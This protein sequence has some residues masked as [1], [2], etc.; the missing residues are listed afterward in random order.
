V[1]KV[2]TALSNVAKELAA[3][4]QARLALTDAE[5]SELEEQLGQ[6][7]AQRTGQIEAHARLDAY[8]PKTGTAYRCPNC[9]IRDGQQSLLKPIPFERPDEDILRCQTCGRDFGISLRR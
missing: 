3:L 1:D 5:I 9:W 7:K 2:E 4:S 8:L 6:L